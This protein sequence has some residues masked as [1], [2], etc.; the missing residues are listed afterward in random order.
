MALLLA[1]SRRRSLANPSLLHL[2]STSSNDPNNDNATANGNHS[3][4]NPPSV[5]SY[6]GDVKTDQ[7]Q[8]RPRSPTNPSTPNSKP[9]SVS[10]SLREIRKNLSEFRRRSAGPS[11]AEPIST[12]SQSQPHISFQELFKRNASAKQGESNESPNGFGTSGKR[13]MENL[14]NSLRHMKQNSEANNNVEGRSGPLISL[15]AF[16]NDLKLKPSA[17]RVVSPVIGGTSTELP[18]SIFEREMKGKAKGGETAMRTE[19]VRMYGYE[20]LGQRLK[21]L[22]PPEKEGGFSLQELNERLKKLRAIEE[23]ETD[24]QISGVNFAAIRD[25]LTALKTSDEEKQKNKLAQKVDILDLF[26]RTPEFMLHP[27]KEHLVEKYFHP[28]NMSSAEKMKIELA[29]VRDEFKMS[30]S[31][32]GSARVQ[33][34]QLTTKIKH[35]SSV[36]HKKDKHSRKG[37][38]AM[39]QKRKKLLKYLRRTDWDS[40]CF[41]LLKLGL[42]DT[43]DSKNY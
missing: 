20:E 27:P 41:V 13:A 11:P 26:G 29:K 25:G 34:A 21:E 14:K 12:P 23:K 37:L 1:R 10:A 24:V 16:K 36:L 40:Y 7:H 33:V 15:S 22:R 43:A 32:C 17:D 30:E 9:M 8:Q 38:Q 28:D 31:D 2:F 18:A 3:A 19:F 39:V 6:F 4:N 42:R 5:S 35:L